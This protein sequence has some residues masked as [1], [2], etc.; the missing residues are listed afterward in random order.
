MLPIRRSFS[1]SGLELSYLEWNQGQK[2]L[3][4]LHGLADQALVW[5]DLAEFLAADYHIIAPDFRGHGESSK[6]LADYRFETV[7]ADL[8]A[9]LEHLGWGSIPVIGHS[10]A[11]K[12]ALIWARSH[13][14]RLQKLILVDPIFVWKFP[15]WIKL[16]F[17]FLFRTLSFAKAMGPFPSYEVALETSRQ[18]MQ[19]KRWSPLQQKVFATGIEQKPDGTWGSKHP[20]W[21]RDAVFT[22]VM[23]VSG[24]TVPLDVPTLFIQPQK[25]VNRFEWQLKPYKTYLKNLQICQVPGNHWVL[26]D[27]PEPFNQAVTAFLKSV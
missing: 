27:E 3:L 1:H 5:S 10:W 17:P 15:A 20:V 24:L 21:A 16:T 11:G 22:E 7:I 4:L 13:P 14:Q 18:L 19:F 8:E 9:L 6:P 26:M 12:V 23:Q 25:G 2:P